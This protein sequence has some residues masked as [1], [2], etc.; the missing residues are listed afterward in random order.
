M[1]K[2]FKNEYILFSSSILFFLVY[3]NLIKKEKDEIIKDT[4]VL[5]LILFFVIY[6]VL[7]IEEVDQNTFRL[8]GNF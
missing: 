6:V 8:D 5:S 4:I 3:S 1:L 2:Y 7:N